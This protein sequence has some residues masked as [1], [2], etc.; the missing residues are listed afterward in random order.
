MIEE[1]KFEVFTSSENLKNYWKLLE[2]EN[3]H[4]IFQSFF[5]AE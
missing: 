3:S 1:Y 2:D 4:D 5:L